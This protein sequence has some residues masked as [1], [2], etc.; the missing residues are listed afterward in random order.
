MITCSLDFPGRLPL[1]GEFGTELV[2][3]GQHPGFPERNEYYVE[4]R[5]NGVFFIT[6]HDGRT[7]RR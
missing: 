2:L 1:D 5:Y 4:N 6:G 3:C 7:G